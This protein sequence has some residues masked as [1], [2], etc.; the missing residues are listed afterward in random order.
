MCAMKC[1][2]GL[3]NRFSGLKRDGGGGG[4]NGKRVEPPATEC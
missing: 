4:E 3:Q 2:D 1:S